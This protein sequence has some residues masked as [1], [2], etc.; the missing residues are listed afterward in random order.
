MAHDYEDL[1]S[2]ESL[3]DTELRDLV[4]EELASHP[5]LDERDLVV[6]VHEGKV[7]LGGRVGTEGERRMAAHVLTDVLGIVEFTDDI[8]IDPLARAE[9][10][11]DIDEHL[12]D[13]ELRAGAV[14][15]DAPEPYSPEA[16]HLRAD[17]QD[18]LT[19]TTDYEKVVGNGLTWNPP[20]NPTPEGLSGSDADPSDF[21]EDH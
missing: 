19:G 8:V 14:L 21:G 2:A 5:G 13:E 20:V 11:M 4:R 17:A 16:E 9:S 7:R 10:P 6:H 15:G 18:D 3:D 1:H 12:A